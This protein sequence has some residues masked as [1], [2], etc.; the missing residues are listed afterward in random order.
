MSSH[1]SLTPLPLLQPTC[2]KL[3]TVVKQLLALKPKAPPLATPIDRLCEV[4]RGRVE[5]RR[6]AIQD[7]WEI[8]QMFVTFLTL[9]EEVRNTCHV[10]LTWMSCDSYMDVM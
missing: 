7:C 2:S 5:G 10:T 1:D 6:A 4:V 8:L 3:D 9:A